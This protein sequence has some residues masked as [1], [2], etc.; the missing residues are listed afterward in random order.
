MI[1]DRF[2]AAWQAAWNSRELDRIMGHYGGDVVFRSAKARAT[3]GD[4]V[5]RG[6]TALRAYWAAALARQPDLRFQVEEVF[7]GE[8]M[9]VLLYTNHAGRRAAET[10][11]FGPHGLVV[12]ASACHGNGAF[13]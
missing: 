3:V 9:L 11:R 6:K 5:V 4:G 10:L 12:E 13:T 7:E 8:D 1:P 2:A